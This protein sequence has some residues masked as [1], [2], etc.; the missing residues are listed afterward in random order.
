MPIDTHAPK[1]VHGT[2]HA[3]K[4]VHGSVLTILYLFSHYHALHNDNIKWIYTFQ[5]SNHAKTLLF[6]YL[7]HSIFKDP[8]AFF[9]DDVAVF[10]F[11][12]NCSLLFWAPSPILW[13][14]SVPTY[15][16]HSTQNKQ[17][18]PCTSTAPN[19]KLRHTHTHTHRKNLRKTYITTSTPYPYTAHR[20]L[21]VFGQYC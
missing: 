2:N 5:H 12:L 9:L 13:C 6:F 16:N 20:I 4:M 15:Q 14:W 8:K 10:H 17:Q 1:V 7:H 21:R 3:P 18:T 11:V 19:T